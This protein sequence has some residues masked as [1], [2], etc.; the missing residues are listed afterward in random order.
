MV[1]ITEE[2]LEPIVRKYLLIRGDWQK[3]TTKE[4]R[5]YVEN[6][7]QLPEK[8]LKDPEKQTILINC[9]V[10]IQTNLLNQKENANEETNSNKNSNCDS[11]SSSGSGSDSDDESDSNK[12][13]SEPFQTKRGRF[14]KAE[15]DAIKTVLDS[16]MTENNI[17]REDLVPALRENDSRVH[18]SVWKVLY[19][20]FP[21]RT[22]RVSTVGRLSITVIKFS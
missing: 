4:L 8:S 10:N 9:V 22:T 21:N 16:F 3:I 6:Q 18:R 15:S 1:T 12:D 20:M 11:N 7:L 17:S 19:N 14:S 5:K 13:R 2:L